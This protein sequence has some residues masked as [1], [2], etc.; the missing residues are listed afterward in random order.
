[1]GLGTIAIYIDSKMPKDSYRVHPGKRELHLISLAVDSWSADPDHL[2][3][4][5]IVMCMLYH[6]GQ[7]GKV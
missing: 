5:L 3:I 4:K 2:F 6:L 7:F 1:M